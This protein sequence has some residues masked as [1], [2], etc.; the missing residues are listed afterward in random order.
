M[1]ET[2]NRDA[3]HLRWQEST[4]F[5]ICVSEPEYRKMEHRKHCDGVAVVENVKTV[6]CQNGGTLPLIC[7]PG[8]ITG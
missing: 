4:G 6:M 1:S 5:G 2:Q 3:N 7:G 8:T